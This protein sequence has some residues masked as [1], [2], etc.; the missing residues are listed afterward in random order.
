NRVPRNLSAYHGTGAGSVVDNVIQEVDVKTGLVEW[1]WHSIG[2]IGLDESEVPPPTQ[3][4]AEWDYM[5]MN[6]V[7][8][9]ANGD[10]LVS[11][12]NTWGVYEIS[13]TTGK[14]VWRLGGKKPT[15][16]MG[17]GTAFAFQHDAREAGDGSITIFDDSAAPPQRKHS[18]AIRISVNT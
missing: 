14:V 7:S 10:L 2:N 1:E 8:E 17:A 16:K 13:R 12:R 15:F 9:M 6:A 11:A 5:H 4:G 3:R 18:R